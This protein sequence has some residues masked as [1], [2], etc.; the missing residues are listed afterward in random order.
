MLISQYKSELQKQTLLYII[1]NQYKVSL[2]TPGAPFYV[3]FIIFM[4]KVK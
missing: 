3:M 1:I 2:K 4:T